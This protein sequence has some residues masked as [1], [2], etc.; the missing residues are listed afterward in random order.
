MPQLHTPRWVG[1]TQV[2]QTYT[3]LWAAKQVACVCVQV[4]DKASCVSSSCR[5]LHSSLLAVCVSLSPGNASFELC[6]GGSDVEVDSS[7][8]LGYIRAVVD[9]TLGS[10]ILAQMVAFSDGFN[11]VRRS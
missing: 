8:L 2:A 5:S 7:N 4:N 9:A 6:P 1:N 3:E 11:E 10:G